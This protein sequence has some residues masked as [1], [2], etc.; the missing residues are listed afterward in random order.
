MMKMSATGGLMV[1]WEG[2]VQIQSPESRQ[3]GI[4]WIHFITLETSE[5]QECQ[6]TFSWAVARIF[7]V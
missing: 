4:S 7:K 3:D 5:E 2:R 6:L 1:E